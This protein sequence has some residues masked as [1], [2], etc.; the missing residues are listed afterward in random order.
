MASRAEW[1]KILRKTIKLE[2]GEGWS[3][4]GMEIRG[5]LKTQVTHR[6]PEDGRRETTFIPYE[7]N[8]RNQTK[9]TTAIGELKRL[10]NERNLTLKEAEKFRVGS[11]EE[12]RATSVTNWEHLSEAFMDSRK[13]NRAPTKRDLKTNMLRVLELHKKKPRPINRGVLM[14][15]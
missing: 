2:N 1:Q 14:Y 11:T 12:G 9:I 7:W 3:V 5:L 4:R 8:S 15:L 10:I 13:G 6:F